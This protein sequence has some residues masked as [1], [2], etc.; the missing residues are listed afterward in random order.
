MHFHYNL[1]AECSKMGCVTSKK[2]I[3]DLHPNIFQVSNVDDVGNRLS[4]GQLEVNDTELVLYQKGKPPVRWPLRSLRRYGHGS[5]VFSFEAGR[6]CPTGSGIYAFSCKRA[7]KL[8]EFVQANVQLRNNEDT[9]S[10]NNE[11]SGSRETGTPAQTRPSS[12]AYLEPIPA[13]NIIST[14]RHSSLPR[15][16]I[17][18]ASQHSRLN[19]VGSSSNGCVSPSPP[20]HIN[21][22]N[23]NDTMFLL[24]DS[25]TSPDSPPPCQLYMNVSYSG[26]PIPIPME[27]EEDDDEENRTHIYANLAPGDSVGPLSPAPLP[28]P[29]SLTYLVLDLDSAGSNGVSS[30][31][32]GQPPESPAPRP[33]EGYVTIDFDK[34]VALSH[35]VN[36]TFCNEGSRKTRHSSTI[37]DLVMPRQSPSSLSD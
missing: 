8:F 3:N 17:Q 37:G 16:T 23:N 21:N 12:G 33:S 13:T 9:V 22:N 5:Q 11:D 25:T 4:S 30:A 14:S 31:S 34:T 28:E 1:L 2:D 24:E 6:R 19:S 7:D 15:L 20:P 10:R 27:Q 36:P 29:R 32:G 26:G 18:Q 35:S